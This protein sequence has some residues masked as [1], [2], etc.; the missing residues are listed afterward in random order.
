MMTNICTMDQDAPSKL[1][2][3]MDQW[4]K[5]YMAERRA[6]RFW[7]AMRYLGLAMISFAAGSLAAGALLMSI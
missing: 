4:W 3:T 2:D 7:M 1:D 6:R 5:D